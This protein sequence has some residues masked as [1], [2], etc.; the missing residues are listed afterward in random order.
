VIKS[1]DYHVFVT[2]EGDCHGLYVRRKSADSFE[3]RE[4]TG[5]KS[6]IAFSYRIVG[7][8]KDIKSHQR[9]RQHRH[10]SP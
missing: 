5:G 9:F 6:D 2:P 4:L 8:R 3:V 10:A 1:C 7:R